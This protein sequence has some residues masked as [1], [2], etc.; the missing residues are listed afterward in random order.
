MISHLSLILIYT[1]YAVACF[2]YLFAKLFQILV[3]ENATFNIYNM[4]LY[5]SI[6]NAFYIAKEV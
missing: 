2:V 6:L 4:N 1:L 5:E 3:V